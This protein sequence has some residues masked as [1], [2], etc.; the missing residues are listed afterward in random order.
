LLKF[1]HL[2]AQT[3][4]SYSL[5]NG[6]NERMSLP[7]DVGVVGVEKEGPDESGEQVSLHTLVELFD[8]RRAVGRLLPSPSLRGL[9]LLLRLTSVVAVLG[10][11]VILNQC[12]RLNE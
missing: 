7:P 2:V 11:L 9:L 3:L 5:V 8:Q 10:R 4:E 6:N 12:V 1:E